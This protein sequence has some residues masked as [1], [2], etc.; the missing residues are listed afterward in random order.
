MNTAASLVAIQLAHF[1]AADPV[2]G[3]AA[4]LF[5][6]RRVRERDDGLS[7]P[8]DHHIAPPTHRLPQPWTKNKR[9]LDKLGVLSYDVVIRAMEG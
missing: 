9:G 1:E 7:N 2:R 8:P 6:P 5:S 4:S 3:L